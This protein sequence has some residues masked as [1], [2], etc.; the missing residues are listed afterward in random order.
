M[1]SKKIEQIKELKHLE[2]SENKFVGIN[3]KIRDL[4]DQSYDMNRAAFYA[5]GEYINY[6][7]AN[8]LKK[9]FITELIN[10]ND[11]ARSFGFASA[12]RVKEGS[13]L[14]A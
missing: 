13:F 6:L 8:L 4:V 1:I 10:V 14:T 7:R 11:L 9:I 2:Y 5:Y 3:D 12:P